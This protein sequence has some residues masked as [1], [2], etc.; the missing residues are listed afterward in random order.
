ME[1]RYAGVCTA[2]KCT[3]WYAT[4]NE[5]GASVCLNGDGSLL[6]VGASGK[7]SAS[8]GYVKVYNW[9]GRGWELMGQAISGNASRDEFG[10][11]TSISHDGKILAIGANQMG[12]G[13]PGYV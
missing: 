3:Q 8:P 13:G 7:N 5:F 10:G 12:N 2:R 11:S 1:S 6:V 4:R 9:D